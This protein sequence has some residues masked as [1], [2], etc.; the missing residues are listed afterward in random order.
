MGT[1]GRSP[2]DPA[3]GLTGSGAAAGASAGS[4]PAAQL[5]LVGLLV[6]RHFRFSSRDPS[7]VW[8][9]EEGEGDAGSSD[10]HLVHLKFSVLR[11]IGPRSFY[12]VPVVRFVLHDVAHALVDD[13]LADYVGA[14]R[15]RM[16]RVAQLSRSEVNLVER[17]GKI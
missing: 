1:A 17:E 14:Q 11:V 10:V 8:I 9:E 6:I 7:F 5:S 4:G 16:R 13:H 3:G 2:T 15:P 12:Q